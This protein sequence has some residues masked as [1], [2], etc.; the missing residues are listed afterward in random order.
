ME[1]KLNQYGEVKGL[2]FGFY[3]EASSDVH[4]LI[5]YWVRARTESSAVEMGIDEDR[6]ALRIRQD[7]M[8]SIGM[9][10]ALG[11]ARLKISILNNAVLGREDRPRPRVTPVTHDTAPVNY[12]PP[13]PLPLAP[14]WGA[15]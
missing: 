14:V 2:A 11:W 9:R 13:L 5:R 15:V 6:A 7:I 4:D 1:S 3:S 8:H 12:L 10:V